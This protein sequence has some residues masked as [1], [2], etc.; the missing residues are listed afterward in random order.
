MQWLVQSEPLPLAFHTSNT[1]CCPKHSIILLCYSIVFLD[2]I[3]VSNYSWGHL[4]T[5]RRS[6]HQ[7][8]LSL[9]FKIQLCCRRKNAA[10]ETAFEQ[11]HLKVTILYVPAFAFLFVFAF[12][13]YQ[14][15]LHFYLVVVVCI[16]RA[17][18]QRSAA[19]EVS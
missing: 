15:Y 11:S 5:L 1:N 18:S 4:H 12:F 14:L 10:E 6:Q 13:M 17:G 2:C 9:K 7:N 16:C 3:I 19:A 8:K